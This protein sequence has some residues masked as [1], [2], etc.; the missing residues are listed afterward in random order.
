MFILLQLPF[1]DLRG[2]HDGAWGRSPRPDWRADN[3][4]EC[5]V[6]NFGGMVT[7]NAKAYGLVGERAYVEFDKAL[8]VPT[9]GEY[10]HEQWYRSVPLRLWY[11]RLYFDGDISGRFERGFHTESGAEYELFTMQDDIA[12][13]LPSLARSVC[14]LP[15]EVRSS[16]GS[17]TQAT[18]ERCGEALGLAYLAATTLNS[19]RHKYPASELMGSMFKVGSASLHIRASSETPVL[20]PEDRRDIVNSD[21]DH[22]FLTSVAKAQRRNTLTVQISEPFEDESANE[23]ARRVLFSHLNSVLFANDFLSATMDA[24]SIAT[25]KVGLK[26]LTLRALNRFDRLIVNAPE[27]KSDEDFVEALR[28]FSS[29]HAGRVDEIVAKLEALKDGATGPSRM[30]KIG[31]WVRGWAEF[32]LTAGIEASVKAS[33]SRV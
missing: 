33:M 27:T 7:R 10:Q 12:F 6:R 8:A 9:P 4:G 23:R 16:D 13:D 18:L 5:F 31:S 29:E 20:I 21:D 26:E 15:I 28:L 30:D 17:R 11:R 19:E 24:K 2:L 32:T 3:P 22:L 1:V 14:D 25:H